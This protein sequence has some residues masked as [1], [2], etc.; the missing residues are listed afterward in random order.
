[1]K[2]IIT[3]LTTLLLVTAVAGQTDS[4]RIQTVCYQDSVIYCQLNLAGY[5]AQQ[6][7]GTAA[8]MT[9]FGAMAIATGIIIDQHPSDIV[10]PI[11]GTVVAEVGACLFF[12]GVP[13]WIIEVSKMNTIEVEMIKYGGTSQ[14]AGVGLKFKF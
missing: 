9:I 2:R 13:L 6:M 1:M 12:V 4:C 3:L 8:T 11:T 5:R 14:G 10:N 7:A